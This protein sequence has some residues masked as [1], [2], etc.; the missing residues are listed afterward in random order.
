MENSKLAKVKSP[1]RKKL[2]AFVI[3]MCR[4]KEPE[5]RI[6]DY[7]DQIIALLEGE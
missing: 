1:D 7:I 5:C 6:N 3:R 4:D 2:R